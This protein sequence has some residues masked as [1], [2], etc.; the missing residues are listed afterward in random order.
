VSIQRPALSGGVPIALVAGGP[1]LKVAPF[2]TPAVGWGR[3]SDSGDSVNGARFL[4]GGG[5]AFQSLTSGVGV[6]VGFQKVFID[7]GDTMFGI[8]LVLGAR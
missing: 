2:L 8:S 1:T 4:L 6:N 5:V 3:V 7:G